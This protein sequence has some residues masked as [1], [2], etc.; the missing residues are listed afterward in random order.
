MGI[1]RH[2]VAGKVIII[3]AL[4]FSITIIGQDSISL[5]AK[6]KVT[7]FDI[8]T[9]RERNILNLY[10]LEQNLKPYELTKKLPPK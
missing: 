7:H 4:L 3:V 9:I 1:H 5:S 8:D 10:Q 2:T 6:E